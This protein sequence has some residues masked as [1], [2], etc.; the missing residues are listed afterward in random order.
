MQAVWKFPL[1]IT[2]HVQS[3]QMP[4]GSQVLTVQMQGDVPTL[5]ALTFEG[6]PNIERR[7]RV[8][9]TGWDLPAEQLRFIATIQDGGFVWHF[10]EVI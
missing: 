8:A 5:W 3:V 6:A 4:G 7:F 1:E 2:R 9:G 10:F